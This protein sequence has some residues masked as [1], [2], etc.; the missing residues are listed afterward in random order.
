MTIISFK[1]FIN[2]QYL[3]VINAIITNATY[4]L[5]FQILF[6]LLFWYTETHGINKFTGDNFLPYYFSLIVSGLYIIPL[7]VFLQIFN[8]IQNIINLNVILNSNILNFLFTLYI[9]I[10]TIILCNLPPF[11]KFFKRLFK[12]KNPRVEL[13]VN[14]VLLIIVIYT[15]FQVK[16]FTGSN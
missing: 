6:N 8:T 10:M 5:I 15:S 7:F 1:N 11:A 4:Y 9:V 3:A 14:F 2:K 12:I 13:I 16:L